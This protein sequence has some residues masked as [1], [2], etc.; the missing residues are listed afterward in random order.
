M[1]DFIIPQNGII[2]GHVG[3]DQLLAGMPLA[4]GTTN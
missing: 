4:C 2:G 1:L 3:A